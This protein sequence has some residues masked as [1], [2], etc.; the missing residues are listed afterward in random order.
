MA[1]EGDQSTYHSISSDFN[2]PPVQATSQA[3]P[4]TRQE[5]HRIKPSLGRQSRVTSHPGAEGS[6]VE[7]R[8]RPG[9]GVE[10][11]RLPGMTCP[12][13][14]FLQSQQ[15]AVCSS[16]G[17]HQHFNKPTRRLGPSVS[18]LQRVSRKLKR[19]A[20]GPSGNKKGESL[21]AVGPNIPH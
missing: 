13:H 6:Q 1:E 8:Y 3:S 7:W 15:G 18:M 17:T 21:P 14:S 5:G 11:S 9:K 10:G 16:W 2:F 20:E 4:L 12:H 19:R